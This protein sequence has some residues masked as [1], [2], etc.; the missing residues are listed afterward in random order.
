MAAIARNGNTAERRF[1]EIL[2]VRQCLENHFRKPIRTIRLIPGRK[3]SDIQVEF[4][5][6]TLARIQNKDGPGNNRGWSVDRRS[7]SRMPLD[8][9]GKQLLD[10]VCLKKAGERPVVERPAGLIHAL[11]M[12]VDPEYTPHYF[13]HSIFHKET[14]ELLQLSIASAERIL[15]ALNETA[16]PQ[17]VAKRTCVHISPLLYLQRKGGGAADASPN[18]IQLK[19]KS[20]PS[21]VMEPLYDRR[22]ETPHNVNNDA[23]P[24]VEEGVLR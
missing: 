21:S 20:L 1:C 3:K 18:D 11:L 15:E 10:N 2:M 9:V 24:E 17:L 13:T 14:G 22:N 7:V 5:D 19:L 12:G 16:Y 23:V 4:M 8:D 6:D